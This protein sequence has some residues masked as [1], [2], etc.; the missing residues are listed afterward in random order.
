MKRAP[1]A[2]AGLAL[3]SLMTPT[4]ASAKPTYLDCV[5]PDYSAYMKGA[6]D[7]VE[8]SADEDSG[9]VSLSDETQHTSFRSRAAFTADRVMFRAPLLYHYAIDRTDLSIIVMRDDPG[10]FTSK[11]KC[12]IKVAPRRAF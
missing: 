7:R 8:V 5:Y 2:Y 9:T 6:P 10:G 11:G 1:L 12:R 3:A 4:G